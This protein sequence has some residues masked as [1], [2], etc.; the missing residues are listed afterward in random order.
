VKIPQISNE[1][2]AE[3][4]TT[5]KPMVYDEGGVVP[6]TFDAVDPRAVSFI[7]SPDG[8]RPV[9]GIEPWRQVRT[10]HTYGSPAL[11]KPSIAEVLAQ[12]TGDL[13]GVVGF[14]ITGPQDADE[15]NAEREALNA[16][17]HVATVTLWRRAP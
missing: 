2:I 5:I 7:W 9:H 10:L 1:R 16:G 13:T 3:M 15:L 14:T 8:L 4:L 6:C 12:L 11:F 17:F